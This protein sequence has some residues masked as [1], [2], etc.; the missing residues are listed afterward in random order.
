MAAE[1]SRAP[2]RPMRSP[3][4]SPRSASTL[5]LAGF[6]I[7]VW[8][9]SRIHRSLGIGFALLMLPFSLGTTAVIMLFNGALWAPALAR[10]LDTSCATRSTRRRAKC[11]S[12][13]CRAS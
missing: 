3:R 9:T 6:V 2:A 5:S 10:V 12:C 4:S 11:C 8:L 7:Q 1:A 13:R